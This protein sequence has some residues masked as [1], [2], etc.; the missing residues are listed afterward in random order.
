[1]RKWLFVIFLLISGDILCQN[2]IKIWANVQDGR[3]FRN[4]EL[5]VFQPETKNTS[6]ISVIIAPGGSYYWL[7]MNN[8]GYKV[9]KQLNKEGITAFVLKYRTARRG[10]HHPAMIQDMQRTLQ[11]VKER[12]EEF[13][14]AA[15][16]VGVMGFSA[17][18]HLA[19]TTG[20]YFDENF[21][22][23]LGIE[24]KISLKPYFVAMI[25][26][27]VSMQDSTAHRKSRR[28][29]LTR[30]FTAEEQNKMSLEQNVRTD[31]PPVFLLHCI[32]DKTVDYHNSVNYDK[33]LS[34][35]NIPHRFL[36]FEK[37]G[38]GFGIQPRNDVK[39]WLNEFIIWL[40]TI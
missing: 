36:L 24:P 15:D 12:A 38:H 29:L 3:K 10:Y 25:Y 19:G 33:T 34:E 8:E 26:P 7:D 23:P 28:N 31:M 1:M 9:A 21:M 2:T 30:N 35:R 13:G 4:S 37:G 20:T 14:I 11:L 6:G 16:K 27:V 18:G 39:D 17:G 22:K 40:K 32:D 5:I